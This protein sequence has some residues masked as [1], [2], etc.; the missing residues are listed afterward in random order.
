MFENL[1]NIIM[2]NNA[3]Y[4]QIQSIKYDHDKS[5]KNIKDRVASIT[6]YYS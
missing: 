1:N 6:E 2:Q 4:Q 3:L 5:I